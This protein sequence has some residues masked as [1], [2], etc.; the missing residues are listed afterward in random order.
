MGDTSPITYQ[1]PA[2][3]LGLVFFNGE[4][5]A[6]RV[7]RLGTYR[8]PLERRDLHLLRAAL[9]IAEDELNAAEKAMT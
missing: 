2:H 3:E 6:Y 8:P 5:G 1:M 7:D 9:R 4:C